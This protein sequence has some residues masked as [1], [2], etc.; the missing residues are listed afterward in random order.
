[1]CFTALVRFSF[2]RWAFFTIFIENQ[3]VCPMATIGD[4]KQYFLPLQQ[5][6]SEKHFNHC[7]VDG[8]KTKKTWNCFD[9]LCRKINRAG[10]KL[11]IYS[12]F[13][14]SF[15]G[16]VGDDRQPGTTS[17]LLAFEVCEHLC[18][19]SVYRFFGS[20]KMFF[21]SFRLIKLFAVR[22][23]E[24]VWWIVASFE[25]F[26]KHFSLS[27][28]FRPLQVVKFSFL[29]GFLCTEHFQFLY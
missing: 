5:F 6:K 26:H 1:M 3:I 16:R 14:I 20:P 10:V 9:I 23:Y 15:A 4:I 24:L 18:P 12:K 28:S 17:R 8:K 11:I 22:C 27:P 21:V 29:F 7:S 13:S 25:C 19:E 2:I